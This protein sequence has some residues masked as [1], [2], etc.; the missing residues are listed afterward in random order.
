M[1]LER[2]AREKEIRPMTEPR[3]VPESEVQGKTVK[4]ALLDDFGEFAVRCRGSTPTSGTTPSRTHRLLSGALVVSKA[5]TSEVG[6]DKS[7]A[8][9][10]CSL[11]IPSICAMP[12]NG[13]CLP[14]TCGA[15][16]A[17]CVRPRRD[18]DLWCSEL[19]NGTW[20]CSC[21]VTISVKPA[22]APICW[23]SGEHF[24]DKFSIDLIGLIAPLVRRDIH[25]DVEEGRAV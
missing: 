17:Q 23:R 3:S 24:D 19:T 18:Q 14:S 21:T 2:E 8:V 20:V 10:D 25:Q 1:D 4:V 7:S 16:V 13:V 15:L 6:P 5:A 22:R 11:A 12:R 9:L